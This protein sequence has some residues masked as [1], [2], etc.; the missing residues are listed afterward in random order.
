MKHILNVLL[1]VLLL[2]NGSVSQGYPAINVHMK[3]ES[4]IK[5]ENM[6]QS[7]HQIIDAKQEIKEEQKIVRENQQK[8][9]I[10]EQ[11]IVQENQQKSREEVPGVEENPEVQLEIL[12]EV[13]VQEK[14]EWKKENSEIQ[15][16]VTQ[17]QEQWEG[18]NSIELLDQDKLAAGDVA[19]E[20]TSEQKKLILEDSETLDKNEKRTGYSIKK[21]ISE[22]HTSELQSP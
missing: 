12:E 8:S 22:E 15:A 3:V 21:N 14:S 10:E 16:E 20:Q 19:L 1:P 7:G 13:C 17:N 6:Q 2:V 5:E 11:K 4:V 18:Y 9:S